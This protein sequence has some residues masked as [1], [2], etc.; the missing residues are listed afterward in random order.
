MSSESDDEYK[1]AENSLSDDNGG[2]SSSGSESSGG[3]EEEEAM[4][5]EPPA[6]DRAF[7]GM[8]F[9]KREHTM[10]WQ[11]MKDAKAVK[12]DAKDLVSKDQP[13]NLM[14]LQI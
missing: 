11:V 13:H 9:T 10:A 1:S 3:E 5:R 12:A 4:P 14:K 7:T 8:R 6:E 2:D